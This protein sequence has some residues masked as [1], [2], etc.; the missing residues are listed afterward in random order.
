MANHLSS[1]VIGVCLSIV[2]VLP[3]LSSAQTHDL[4]F[5]TQDFPP[6][7]YL[8]DEDISGPAVEVVQAICKEAELDCGFEMLPWARAQKHVATGLAN[9]MFL[10]AKNPERA[11]SLNFSYPLFKGDYGFFVHKTDELEYQSP[12]D[13]S[14][15][16]VAVY[17]PSNTAIRL[18]TI[19]EHAS[20]VSIDMRP[21]D[22]SGFRKLNSRR[23]SAVFS[24]KYVGLAM[25]H[26][27]KMHSIR[28]AGTDSSVLYY[29][30]FSKKYT[31]ITLVDKFNA[32]YLRLHET[33]Q[34]SEI[35]KKYDME[36]VPPDLS[37]TSQ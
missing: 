29:V 20:K 19:V 1:I 37:L 5:A 10:L 9:A 16:R 35:L 17:G 18:Q 2:V 6:Y 24:N 32:A 14:G 4:M 33:Q 12:A 13:I 31:G 23:V 28:Y 36:T 21:D 27:M 25:I 15:Y 8:I 7:S 11:L 30:G 34:I 3:C 26:K 22:E